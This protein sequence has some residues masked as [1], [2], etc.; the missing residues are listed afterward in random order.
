MSSSDSTEIRHATAKGLAFNG[1]CLGVIAGVGFATDTWRSALISIGV[2]WFV[3]VVH[4]YPQSSEK[5]FD[6]TGTLTY[7]TLIVSALLLAPSSPLALGLRP[8]V[9][10][11][12]VLVWSIRL[13]SY[14][15]ARIMRDGKDARFDALKPNA[16]FWL[17]IW[18]MQSLW[19]YLVALPALIIISQP[20]CAPAPS[21][22]DL[23]GWSL[24]A[25]GMLFEVLADLQKATWRADPVNKGMFI[26]SGLWA[27]SRHPNYFGEI[28]LWIGICVSGTSCFRGTELLGWLSPMTTYI[29]LLYVSGVPLLE[30]TADERWSHDPAYQWYKEHTPVVF[31]RLTAPPPYKGQALLKESP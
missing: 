21:L 24:W 1:I 13:G 4:A 3:F 28:L 29:L 26:H 11:A 14:L 15:L 18:S 20:S 16:V 22:L 19:C 8:L 30:K 9:L 25:L 17:G 12:M 6:A 23:A 10:A 5:F 7:V 27:Y 31:P 2:N